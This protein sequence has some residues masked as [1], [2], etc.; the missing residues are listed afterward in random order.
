MVQCLPLLNLLKDVILVDTALDS[1][2]P[3]SPTSRVQPERIAWGILL[4]SFAIFCASCAAT[5]LGLYWFFFQSTV[6]LDVLA[7]SGRGTL[8]VSD[9]NGSDQ[10][11]RDRRE[12]S[13]NMSIRTDTTDF[14]SQGTVTFR[15]LRNDRLVASV[16]LKSDT[17]L[18]LSNASRPRFDW[19][20]AG[21]QIDLYN[22]VGEVNVF[23]APGLERDFEMNIK[24]TF[25]VWIR[26]GE[27]GQYTVSASDTQVR[28]LN[29]A[30]EALLIAPGL[31]YGRS[32]DMGQQGILNQGE[33]DITTA[34]LLIDL[35][36]N[37]KMSFATPDQLAAGLP[38][39]WAC[40]NEANDIP[41]GEHAAAAAPDGREAM[42]LVRLENA[43]T[44]GETFC[45]QSLGMPQMGYDVSA[46]NYLEM[47]AT[48]YISEQSLSSCGEQASECPLMMRITFEGEDGGLRDW[49]QGIY[50]RRDT[51]D[52]YPQRCGS[53]FEN[54]LR[55]LDHV[56]YTYES[57]N[58]FD[59][60][61]DTNPDDEFN[62]RPRTILNIRIY[63]SGHQY[64][65]YVGN[66]A[67]VAGNT[68]NTTMEDAVTNAG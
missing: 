63:A 51:N 27:S 18:S 33:T 55:I 37:G 17:T 10:S 41:R 39:N 38:S 61:Q 34:P 62:S 24:T 42:H 68:F 8:G 5:S 26:L 57:R 48:L 22:L 54:H 58:L 45:E 47:R 6:Q 15:D 7:Q 43:D 35:I 36:Q 16:T 3:P 49:Y 28:L 1:N 32:I 12:L 30:G 2:T 25:G 59:L 66:V 44:H 23:V 31:Q 40:G 65:V 14:W 20:S 9:P 56:W 19:I 52:V 4:I 67:L 46:F 13:K 11:V 64:D 53:C 50:A 29:Y 60:F 21:Y